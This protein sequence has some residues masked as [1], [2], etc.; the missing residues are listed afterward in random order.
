MDDLDRRIMRL[1]ARA[2]EIDAMPM[3][4]KPAAVSLLVGEMVAFCKALIARV[5]D[6]EGR[7]G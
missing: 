7:N 1:E 6:L 3:L 4:Q 5:Q 2:E